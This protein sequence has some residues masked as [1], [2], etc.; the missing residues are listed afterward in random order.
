M[1]VS[2]LSDGHNLGKELLTQVTVHFLRRNY[3]MSIKVKNKLHYDFAGVYK[4]I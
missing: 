3:I 2:V 4:A 1:S